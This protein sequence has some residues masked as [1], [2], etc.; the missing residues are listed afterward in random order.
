MF[1]GGRYGVF[2]DM[3]YG[4]WIGSIGIIGTIGLIL[5][6]RNLYIENKILR[7]YF[8]VFLFMSLGNS[9]FYGLLTAVIALNIII[10]SSSLNM[11]D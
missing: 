8:V 4:Y 1:V 10:I 3:E 5:L 2:Y 11:N 6:F 7:L 9:L